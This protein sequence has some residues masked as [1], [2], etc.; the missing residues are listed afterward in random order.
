[1]S[2]YNRDY[3]RDERR[4]RGGGPSTWSVV[5]KLLVLNAAV[6]VFN[7]LLFYNPNRDWFGLSLEALA[8]GRVWT[9][10]TYQFVHANLWHLLANGVGL[11]FLGRMLLQLTAPQHVVRVYLL[12]GLAG[13]LFQL[14]W[15][16]IFGDA[17]IVGA[18]GSVLA[19]ALAT[20]T[21]IPHQRIQL[22]LFFVIPLNLSMRQI[23]WALVIINVLTLA[24]SFG[25]PKEDGVAVMAHFGGMLLG[26]AYVRYGWHQRNGSIKLLRRKGSSRPKASARAPRP[27]RKEKQATDATGKKEPFVTKD[28]DAILDKINAEGF[29]SLSPEERTILERGSQDLSKRIERD[30]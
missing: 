14:G 22:L 1:M 16:A 9:L 10:I 7:D 3:M 2:I 29:Q 25:V 15:N 12:G 20:A 19:I 11:F 30:S 17:I 5:T 27:S 24:F 26:W 23:A 21:I 18:S 6:Y 8:S 4:P 28:I 13:A